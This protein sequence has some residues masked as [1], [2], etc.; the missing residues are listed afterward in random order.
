MGKSD[1]GNK[2]LLGE[3]V[4]CYVERAFELARLELPSQDFDNN[5]FDSV[6]NLFFLFNAF[7]IHNG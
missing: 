3:F 6:V 5:L 2:R 7:N 4:Q 1:F